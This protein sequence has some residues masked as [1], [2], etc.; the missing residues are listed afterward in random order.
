LCA[1]NS[2]RASFNSLSNPD[3]VMPRVYRRRVAAAM[4]AIGFEMEGEME[5]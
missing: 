2:W 1:S 5:G 4:R 3:D